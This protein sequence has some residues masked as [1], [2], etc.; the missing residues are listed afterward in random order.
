MALVDELLQKFQAQQE[1]ANLRNEQRYQE[2]LGIFDQ[3][4]E[5]YKTGGTFEKATEAALERGETKA[6]ASGTQALVSSGLASTTQAGGLS[7]KYQEE[8]AA[9]ARLQAADVS[10]QRLGG[11]LTQKAG[12]IERREDTGPSFS[13]IAELTKSIG[14]GQQASASRG[15]TPIYGPGRGVRFINAATGSSDPFRR[16]VGYR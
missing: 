15:N 8:V 3:L 16:I 1:A 12:F 14:A 7:K 10:A 6:V 5:Q 4:I 11:A 13:D 2:G 9:P